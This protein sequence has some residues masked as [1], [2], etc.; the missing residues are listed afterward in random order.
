MTGATLPQEHEWRSW[1]E[2]AFFPARREISL[3]VGALPAISPGAVSQVLDLMERQVRAH[4]HADE[5][6]LAGQL[7]VQVDPR[8]STLS[9]ESQGASPEVVML[10]MTELHR[11]GGWL[12]LHASVVAREGRAVAISGVSGAG[13][14]TALLRLMAEGFEV[15]AEDRAFWHAASGQ[16][17]G[18]DRFLRAFRDSLERF[19]PQWLE[20]P[21]GRDIKGKWMLP[22]PES[23]SAAL[24]RV[25]LLGH[26]PELDP[27]SR[28]RAAWEMTGTPLTATARAEAQRGVSRLMPLIDS[29]GA[30]REGVMMGVRALLEISAAP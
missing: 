5:L 25:L 24:Q 1:W 19:A 21:L 13:K 16:V 26:A 3:S 27:I 30:T 9:C 29:R 14:S 10:A 11:A 7:Y 15:V 23:R 2:T 20:Q 17:V 18:L 4:W 8:H 6:W 12:P 22:L 28:V